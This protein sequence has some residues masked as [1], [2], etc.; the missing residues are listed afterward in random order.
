MVANLAMSDAVP[1]KRVISCDKAN[2]LALL[3][4]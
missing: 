3:R 2:M 4:L 1:V